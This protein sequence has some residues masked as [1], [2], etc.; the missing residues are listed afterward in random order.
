MA[1]P[2]R[3]PGSVAYPSTD[4]MGEHLLQRLIANLLRALVGQ[5]LKASRRV[6]TVGANQFVYWAEGDPRRCRA[7]DVYVIEGLSRSPERVGVWKTWEGHAPSF[8][9]EVVS[10]D[11]TKDYEA[12]PRD[13]DAMGV[14]ELV[15][16]DPWVTSRSRKRVRWQVFRRD[17]EKGLVVIER[18]SSDRVWS[19]VLGCWLRS[20]D[21]ERGLRVRLATGPEGDALIPTASAHAKLRR[22]IAEAQAEAERRARQEAEMHARDAEMHAKEAEARIAEADAEIARLRAE[23]ARSRRR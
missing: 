14:R 8:A 1:A 21:G 6:A 2:G 17:A 23:L 9:F 16:F 3:S 15:V 13:Y 5:W 18:S 12:A 19:A 22:R 10:D 4:D 11:I 20:V 7:P